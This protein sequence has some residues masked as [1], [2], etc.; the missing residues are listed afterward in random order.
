MINLEEI[1]LI[2]G[3]FRDSFIFRDEKLYELLPGHFIIFFI[4]FIFFHKDPIQKI[5]IIS[6][7]L[8]FK[9]FD[10]LLDLGVG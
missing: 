9:L 7:I 5:I 10:L 4:F 8:Y 3:T 2:D 6:T 1:L